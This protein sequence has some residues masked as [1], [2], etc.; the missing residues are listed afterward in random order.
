MMMGSIYKPSKNYNRCYLQGNTAVQERLLYK[1]AT[2][3]LI[4]DCVAKF[5]EQYPDWH[6]EI[7]FL[8]QRLGLQYR[9]KKKDNSAAIK[10]E[11]LWNGS[12]SENVNAFLFV[13]L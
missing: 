13:R 6:R 2:E 7:P 12:S 9:S 10:R 3:D 4:V 1:L 11:I 5:R 8:L